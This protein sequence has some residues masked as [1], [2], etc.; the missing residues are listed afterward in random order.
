MIQVLRAGSEK[1]LENC[2]AGVFDDSLDPAR[3]REFLA[4]PR[5]HLVVAMDDGLV[6]GFISAV[7]YVHPDKPK[8]ELWINEVGVGRDYRQRGIGKLLMHQT[9][10][11]AKELN[12][13]EGW[14]L[15]SRS[16]ASAM[17]LY[18]SL[19]G[20]CGSDDDVMVT[21]RIGIA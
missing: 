11:L 13:S 19:G 4:D 14:V 15:T 10:E 6:V 21:F 16:N 17:K 18:E 7:H 9:L 2:A 5:H 3:T 8:H 12:C 20:T 1:L